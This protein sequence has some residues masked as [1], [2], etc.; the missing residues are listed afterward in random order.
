MNKIVYIPILLLFWSCQSGKEKTADS[1]SERLVVATVNYPLYYFAKA[2]GGDNVQVYLPSL[3]GDPAYWK[4]DARMV[5]NF[6]KADLIIANGAGYAKWMEKVSLPSSKIVNTSLS[7]KDQWIETEE[8]ITHSHGPEGEHVHKGTAFTTW[9]DLQFAMKQTSS[10]YEALLALLP[11]KEAELK[12][13]FKQLQE[14][15]SELDNKLN[16]LAKTIGDQTLIGSHPVYQYLSSGYDLTIHS[17]HWEPDEMP[18]EEEWSS[19]QNK[20]Q[21]SGAQIML[22][23]DEPIEQI[24]SKL[25]EI[26]MGYSVFN[27]CG[28]K[29]E[30]ADF[31]GVM[32]KNAA[33]LENILLQKIAG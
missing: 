17:L 19:L 14:R 26:G 25:N 13:N 32:A 24:K 33:D 8:G 31:L 3:G 10:V 20:M 7:F 29:P 18:N 9:L 11:E 4:P 28:N 12:S 27:P 21:S 16:E 30:S 5:S 6:Q 1:S 15:L 2:I 22:W 23:E